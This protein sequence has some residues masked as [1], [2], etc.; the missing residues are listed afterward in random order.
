MNGVGHAVIGAI[1][2]RFE[3]GNSVPVTRAHITLAELSELEAAIR[4][5]PAPDP[6]LDQASQEDIE[7]AARAM[8]LVDGWDGW[9]TASGFND[10]LS[11]ND[12]EDER[13]H[14]RDLAAAALSAYDARRKP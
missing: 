1:K 9:D 10:T 11:G 7:V 13:A 3:S 5:Q 4:T 6:L 8:A 12:P 2:A 14:Y